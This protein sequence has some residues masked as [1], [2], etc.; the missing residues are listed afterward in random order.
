MD[1]LA[2]VS[3]S[4]PHTS[5]LYLTRA[6][7]VLQIIFNEIDSPSSFV[8]VSKRFY[9]FSQDPYVRAHYFLSRYGSVQA[10]YWA[11][12][13]GRLITEQVLDVSALIYI[14]LT[15][16]YMRVLSPRAG[17]IEQRGTSLPLPCANCGPPLLSFSLPF[18][19][20]PLGADFELVDFRTFLEA[21]V[22][23]IRDNQHNERGGRWRRVP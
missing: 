11:L 8:I 13:R 23:E 20:D 16:S 18:H 15:S 1:R 19:Q 4:L 21:I 17:P 12:G 2:G 22:G 9:L 3:P 6:D 10:L 14:L 5:R 7:E